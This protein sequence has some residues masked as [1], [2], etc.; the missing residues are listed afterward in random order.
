VPG[1][2][3]AIQILKKQALGFSIHI[4]RDDY[5]GFVPPEFQVPDFSHLKNSNSALYQPVQQM[6]QAK[7][8]Q[9]HYNNIWK[10][11]KTETSKLDTIYCIKS[12]IFNQ[13]LIVYHRISN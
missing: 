13:K 8:E 4:Q 1:T 6:P 5:K 12:S 11:Y 2:S 9:E 7:T 3:G 10:E